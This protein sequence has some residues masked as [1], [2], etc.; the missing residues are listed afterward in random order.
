[1]DSTITQIPEADAPEMRTRPTREPRVDVLRN[2]REILLIAQ[3]PGVTAEGLSIEVEDGQVRIAGERTPRPAPLLAGAQ[4]PDY[5]RAF[6]LPKSVEPGTSVAAL[7][8]GLLH[9]H[10][11][12]KEAVRPR[13]IPVRS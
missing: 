10:M 5:Y 12:L 8:R 7:S 3:L 6:R 13:R 2:E 11:P 9:Q 4:P 1:M